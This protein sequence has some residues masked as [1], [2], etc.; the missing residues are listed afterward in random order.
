[1]IPLY[2]LNPGFGY[3]LSAYDSS[4][5]SQS[6]IWILIES[7]WFLYTGSTVDLDTQWVRMSPLYSL[8]PR[9]GYSMRANDSPLQAQSWIW[10]LNESEWFPFTVSILDL[11]TQ[12]ERMI[13]QNSLNPGFGYLM[14]ANDSPKQSQSWT[15]ILN[16]SEWFPYT[17]S[18][19]D[20]DTQWERMIPLYRVNPWFGYS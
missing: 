9:F 18:T 11:D 12:W 4:I 5:Q 10:I 14:R 7:V 2:S 8:N 1:M 13:P 3:S 19:V 17:G 20:L 16:E 15:W 6:W